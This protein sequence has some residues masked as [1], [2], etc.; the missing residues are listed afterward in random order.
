[1]EQVQGDSSSGAGVIN[2]GSTAAASAARVSKRA[3]GSSF[4]GAKGLRERERNVLIPKTAA[5]I[6]KG[7]E[8]ATV[9]LRG[10]IPDETVKE[11]HD[12]R[13]RLLETKLKSSTD[14]CIWLRRRLTDL[15]KMVEAMKVAMSGSLEVGAGEKAFTGWRQ[16]VAVNYPWMRDR[17]REDPKR[18]TYIG[19]R[20]PPGV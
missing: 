1:M 5:E 10:G 14:E 19:K 20:K 9:T 15:E 7:E 6:S 2:R 16:V 13:V 4:G 11:N 8:E 17:K 18:Y 12:G 3:S